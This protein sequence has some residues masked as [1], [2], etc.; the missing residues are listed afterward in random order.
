VYPSKEEEAGDVAEGDAEQ[1]GL[2]ARSVAGGDGRL[3]RCSGRL[4]RRDGRRGGGGGRDGGDGRGAAL[5]LGRA[6]VAA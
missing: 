5:F 1:A 2:D 3:R 4:G 6:V